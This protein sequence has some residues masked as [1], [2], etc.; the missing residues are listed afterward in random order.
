L[1]TTLLFYSQGL[2]FDRNASIV[3]YTH[4]S[5]ERVQKSSLD[6]SDGFFSLVPTTEV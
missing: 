3:P 6:I 2:C 4:P 1:K 5:M